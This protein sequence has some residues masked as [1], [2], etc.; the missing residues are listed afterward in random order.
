MSIQK[1]EK[2]W[3]EYRREQAWKL[4]QQGWK[5]K[6]IATAL[7]VSEGAV[8]QW[9][10]RGRLGELAARQGPGKAPGLSG[11]DKA[12]LVAVL[13]KGAAAAGFAG[14]VWTQRRVG[15]IIQEHF[16]IS[17]SERHIGRILSQMGYTLQKPIAQASQRNE[18][19][20]LDWQTTGWAEVKKKPPLR[21]TR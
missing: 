11:E 18:Q 17:Y 21:A 7:G 10:M 6:D 16:G 20:I 2:T 1:D 3:R 15:Q 13:D 9:M 4:K 8:S 12:Q 5:Q 14:E 19:A